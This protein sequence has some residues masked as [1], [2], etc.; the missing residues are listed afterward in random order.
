MQNNI[1]TLREG[2]GLTQ[3]SLGQI[4]GV[5]ESTIS[6]YENGK[7]Q[8]PQ[9]VLIKLANYF[10]VSVDYL[11]GM[12]EIEMAKKKQPAAVSDSEMNAKLT[13]MMKDLPEHD[14]QRVLDFVA[15]L[16]AARKEPSSQ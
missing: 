14:F 16:K 5:A 11:L 13:S 6:L 10:S 15:G 1:R 7:R 9:D 8:P 2:R 12:D 3:K 4:I